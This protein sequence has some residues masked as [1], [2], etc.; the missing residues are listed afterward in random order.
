MQATLTASMPKVIPDAE[1]KVKPY[2][3]WR[4]RTRL[5]DNIFSSLTSL[6]G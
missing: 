5:A 3:A 2:I 4:A 1:E 6:N